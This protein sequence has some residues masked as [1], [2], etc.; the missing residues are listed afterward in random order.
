MRYRCLVCQWVYDEE[1]EGKK[2]DE[3]PSDWV[4]PACNASKDQFELINDGCEGE[5]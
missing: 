3:L 2:F 1:K 4:C 5:K